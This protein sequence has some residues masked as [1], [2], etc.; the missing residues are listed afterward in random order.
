MSRW[1]SVSEDF[2]PKITHGSGVMVLVAVDI[3]D[4]HIMLDVGWYWITRGFDD[5]RITHW[6]PLPEP[7]ECKQ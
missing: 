4:G 5:D 7:P 1:I 2:K 6:M 3:G